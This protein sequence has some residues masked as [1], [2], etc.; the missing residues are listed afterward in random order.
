MRQTS[1]LRRLLPASIW[2][3]IIW[4]LISSFI[5][6][7][8]TSV[9]TLLI[10]TLIVV[11]FVAIIEVKD[12]FTDAPKGESVSCVVIGDAAADFSYENVNLAFNKLLA[13]KDPKLISMGYNKYYRDKGELVIDLGAYTRALEFATGVTATVIGKPSPNYFKQALQLINS[14][15]DEC[16]MIGDD[17]VADVGAAQSI[18]MSGIQVKTGKFRPTIDDNHPTVKPDYIADN[19]LAAIKYVLHHNS[20]VNV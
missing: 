2:L 3:R 1:S 19:F 16:V 12:E 10:L 20:T 18:G 7:S 17:I 15:P 4:F 14:E 6:V 13:M 5:Q 8:W 11:S 9:L